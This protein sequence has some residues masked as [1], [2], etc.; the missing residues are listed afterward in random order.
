MITRPATPRRVREFA[1]ELRRYSL[2]I[3]RCVCKEKG[4]DILKTDDRDRVVDAM[5]VYVLDNTQMPS[6]TLMTT[7]LMELLRK[8][9]LIELGSLTDVR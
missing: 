4:I 2:R 9:R 8:Y 7:W 5:T 3:L 6:G 1:E